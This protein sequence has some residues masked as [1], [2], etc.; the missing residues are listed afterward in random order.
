MGGATKT[1]TTSK[2]YICSQSLK[3]QTWLV[4]ANLSIWFMKTMDVESTR[5]SYSISVLSE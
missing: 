3:E 5:G 4:A 2:A 1:H